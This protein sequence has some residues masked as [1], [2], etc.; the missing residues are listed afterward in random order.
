MGS[1]IVYFLQLVLRVPFELF[2]DTINKWLGFSQVLLQK[3]LELCPGNGD[4]L[5]TLV[6]TLVLRLVHTNVLAEEK[7]CKGSPVGPSGPSG[8]KMVFALLTEVITVYIQVIIIHLRYFSLERSLA[9][10]WR[11]SRSLVWL[12]VGLYEFFEQ[13]I[14]R[15]R[16][17]SRSG[18]QSGNLVGARGRVARRSGGGTP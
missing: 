10:C 1:P 5:L 14:G 18:N 3:G 11:L 7:S 2:P 13:F 8:L 12:Q 4:Q 16:S 9:L 6:A 15:G 17:G